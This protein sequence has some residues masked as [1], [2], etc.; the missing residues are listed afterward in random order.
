MKIWSRLSVRIYL[1]TRELDN[2]Y[3]PDNLNGGSQINPRIKNVVFS[4]CKDSYECQLDVNVLEE[5]L[6]TLSVLDAF[7]VGPANVDFVQKA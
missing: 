1:E 2:P 4:M 6:V 7:G 3:F 5:A